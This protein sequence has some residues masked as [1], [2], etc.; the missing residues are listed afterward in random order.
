[1]PNPLPIRLSPQSTPRNRLGFRDSQWPTLCFG[2]HSTQGFIASLG[3]C[4]GGLSSLHTLQAPRTFWGFSGHGHPSP[5]SGEP[6]ALNPLAPLNNPEQVL[7]SS[8]IFVVPH[9]PCIASGPVLA[10][11]SAPGCPFED[12]NPPGGPDFF[13]SL[14]RGRKSPGEPGL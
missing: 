2:S 4:L 5:T 13:F 9:A 3:P 14:G 10:P 1:M 6:L 7:A 12:A 8:K 11:R